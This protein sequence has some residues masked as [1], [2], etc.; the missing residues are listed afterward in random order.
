M[1]APQ[2]RRLCSRWQLRIQYKILDEISERDVISTEA[3]WKLTLGEDYTQGTTVSN[4][5]G[6]LLGLLE[7]VAPGVAIV[8]LLSNLG[9]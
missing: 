6:G 2:V 1:N 9:K 8:F 7:D 4:G 3:E 5:L